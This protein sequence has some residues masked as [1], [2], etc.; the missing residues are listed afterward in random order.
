MNFSA[1][2]S[3]TGAIVLLIGNAVAADIWVAGT[4]SDLFGAGSETQPYRTITFA[5]STAPGS[6]AVV[7]KVK[8]GTYTEAVGEVFPLAR[9]GQTGL[10]D[11]ITISGQEAAEVNYPQIGGDINDSSSSVESVFLIDA[12][13]ASRSGIV[14]EHVRVVAEDYTGRDAP[15]AVFMKTAGSYSVTD[16]V[17]DGLIV[18]RLAQ[19][20]VSDPQANGRA[21]ILL[22]GGYGSLSVELKLCRVESNQRG[23]IEVR[24]GS[25]ASSSSTSATIAATIDT[26]T[27]TA[28]EAE[29]SAFGIQARGAGDVVA[30]FAVTIR[31]CTVDATGAGSEQGFENGIVLAAD[32]GDDGDIRFPNSPTS[33]VDRN[34]IK[35]CVGGG[36]LLRAQSGDG[37]NSKAIV[38]P[39][40]VYRNDIRM[41]GGGVLLDWGSEA[42]SL[43]NLH[44]NT[45]GNLIVDNGYGVWMAND[46][47]DEDVS[48]WVT[49][50][51]DTIANNEDGYAVYGPETAS[52]FWPTF[53][54]AIVYGNNSGGVQHYGTAGW[55]PEDAIGSYY[56][57]NNSCWQGLSGGDPASFGDAAPGFVD[58][59]AGN[60]HLACGSPCVDAGDNTPPTGQALP[61]LDIDGE[62]RAHPAE[63]GYAA[64]VDMGSD[65]LTKDSCP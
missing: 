18:E 19:N 47:G 58:A 64:R 17:V 3:V 9:P 34:L 41:N 1:T 46:D 11:D 15:S 57:V 61:R 14:V 7:I 22:E 51:N 30:E 48:Y 39:A 5:L 38:R 54:N 37:E 59:S 52:D 31:N 29:A 6:G 32:A 35:G 36:L 8:A 49:S 60:Y 21:P 33:H 53:T 10:T 12:T 55:D 20:D 13:S 25:S 63:T 43:N 2:L 24:V 65:E 16:C 56:A 42:G 26:C 44:V 23:C 50:C 4:G 45:D 27:V 40:S 28:V 62:E